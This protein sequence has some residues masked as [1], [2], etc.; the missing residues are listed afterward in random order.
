MIWVRLPTSLAHVQAKTLVNL[1]FLD[2]MFLTRVQLAVT[3]GAIIQ[4]RVLGGVIGLAIAQAILT[5]SLDTKLGSFLSKQQIA[6]LLDSTRSISNFS[7]SQAQST[8]QVYGDAFNLQ[9]RIAT[10]IAAA[11]FLISLG[12]FQRHPVSVMDRAK[13]QQARILGAK[14]EEVELEQGQRR[15]R[16][17]EDAQPTDER[18][19][20]EIGTSVSL[21]Q[22]RRMW[23]WKR[24]S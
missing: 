12:A 8:R 16:V 1:Q 15:G 14:A 6:A 22:K 18:G 5:R 20:G 2:W 13:E 17:G 21:D 11:N 10:F 24:S 7:P 9:M 4:V 19:A 3:M 23:R